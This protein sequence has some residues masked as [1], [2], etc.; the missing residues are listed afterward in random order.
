MLCPT[1]NH[2]GQPVQPAVITC[3][4]L[5]ITRRVTGCRTD[6]GLLQGAVPG[7]PS[8]LAPH[9]LAAVSDIQGRSPHRPQPSRS[10]SGHPGTQAP[11][12]TGFAVRRATEGTAGTGDRQ[13]PRKRHQP[14]GVN[15]QES[16]VRFWLS[17]CGILRPKIYLQHQ[18]AGPACTRPPVTKATTA[19]TL[20]SPR[21]RMLARSLVETCRAPLGSSGRPHTPSPGPTP[22]SLLRRLESRAISAPQQA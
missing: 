2:P 16:Q 10:T 18:Q 14:S 20:L 21:H 17:V 4:L 15:I 1:S 6:E 8:S 19:E 5:S 22:L 3:C 13:G 12:C 11:G 7:S 9:E